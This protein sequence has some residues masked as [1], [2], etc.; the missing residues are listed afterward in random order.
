LPWVL[1]YGRARAEVASFPRACSVDTRRGWPRLSLRHFAAAVDG[2]VL[3][4]GHKESSITS[5]FRF[6][7]RWSGECIANSTRGEG[8]MADDNELSTGVDGELKKGKAP[9]KAHGQRQAPEGADRGV[10]SVVQRMLANGGCY[11]PGIGLFMARL[12]TWAYAT[13]TDFEKALF[14]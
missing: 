7:R 4:R 3:S 9:Q 5:T 14:S 8:E 10:Q 6:G 12:S 2:S 1:P 11:D 13:Q